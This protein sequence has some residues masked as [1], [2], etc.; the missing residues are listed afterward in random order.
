[1]QEK[2]LLEREYE[3]E[4][5]RL[6]ELMER[7][8]INGLIEEEKKEKERIERSLNFAKILHEQIRMNEQER[9]LEYERKREESR[10]ANLHAIAQQEAEMEKAKERET[11]M[12]KSRRELVE[13]NERLKH[14]RNMEKEEERIME[15]RFVIYLQLYNDYNCGCRTKK[16]SEQV[17]Q[18]YVWSGV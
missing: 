14:F 16:I 12:E 2:K 11:E 6:N 18:V 5:K 4:E 17:V 13:C 8:R 10:L 7:E 1:M 3:Q 9:M 15:M